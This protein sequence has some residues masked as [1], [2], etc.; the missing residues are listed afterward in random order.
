MYDFSLAKQ[1]VWWGEY[2]D[3]VASFKNKFDEARKQFIVSVTTK[4]QSDVSII[5][6]QGMLFKQCIFCV[7]TKDMHSPKGR[8]ETRGRSIPRLD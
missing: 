2:Q 6:G 8:N 4:T 3:K 5:L 7:V 1:A